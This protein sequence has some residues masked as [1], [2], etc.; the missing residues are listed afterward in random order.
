MSHLANIGD[1]RTLVI[2]PASTTHR[3]LDEAQQLAAG[4][5]P[6]MVRHVGRPR[7]RRRHP[8]GH[9]PGA[10]T[11]QRP[12]PAARRRCDGVAPLGAAGLS[13]LSVFARYATASSLPNRCG[14]AVSTMSASTVLMTAVALAAEAAGDADGGRHPDAG[15]GGQALHVV[16][17]PVLDDR[18]G[19]EEADAGDDAL[20]DPAHVADHHA[21]LLRHEHEERRADRHQHVGAQAGRLAAPFPLVAERAAERG[22]EEQPRRRCA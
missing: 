2:H 19:A 20:D 1:T 4:V 17:R 21:A 22:G 13:S 6:D 8:L 11:R 14:T 15:G 3:Q 5:P 9:R 7:A 10:R 16:L 12:E 18:A